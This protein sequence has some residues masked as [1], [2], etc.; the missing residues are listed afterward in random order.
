VIDERAGDS[1]RQWSSPPG[2]RNGMPLT[3]RGGWKLYSR[4]NSGER[5]W[6]LV[7][8]GGDETTFRIDAGLFTAIDMANVYIDGVTS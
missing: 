5:R 4:H 7:S 6:N 8:P 1:N 3:G 2:D